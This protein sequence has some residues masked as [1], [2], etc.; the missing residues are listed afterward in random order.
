MTA[1]GAA[2]AFLEEALRTSTSECIEW[3][4]MRRRDGYGYMNVRGRTV[5]VPRMVCRAKY[6]HPEGPR[7]A[8]H[9]CNN[10]AC[11]NY[12]HLRWATRSSNQMDRVAAGTS[13]RGERCGASRLTSA[14]VLDIVRRRRAG[15]SRAEVAASYGITPLHVSSIMHGRAWGWLTGLK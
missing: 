1:Y 13:N 4:F 2:K 15:E 11:V 10:R 9:S 6:G 12:Q 7:D 8:A 3:P 14:D 5:S